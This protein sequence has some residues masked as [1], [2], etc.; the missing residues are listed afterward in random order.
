MSCDNTR[1]TARTSALLCSTPEACSPSACQQACGLAVVD[2]LLQKSAGVCGDEVDA[3]LDLRS[4]LR[5]MEDAEAILAIFCRLRRSLEDR[6][7]LDFYRLRRWLEN[8]VEV[9]F[10]AVRGGIERRLPLK[11][12]GYC[13]E[14]VRCNCV[15][16]AIHP[17]EPLLAPRVSFKF[18]LRQPSTSLPQ[19]FELA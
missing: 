10:V 5:R 18:R 3:L 12:D 19:L 11:L 17:G 15:R 4:L 14:A 6:F 13:L 16:L 7:Y 2:A 8:H 1:A 9:R